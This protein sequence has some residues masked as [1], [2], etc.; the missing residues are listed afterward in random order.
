MYTFY[1][2]FNKKSIEEIGGR[3]I[4]KLKLNDKIN[5]QN[6]KSLT[7]C[8]KLFHFGILLDKTYILPWPQFY[9]WYISWLSGVLTRIKETTYMYLVIV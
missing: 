5:K 4:I 9:A 6:K 7:S 2:C 1:I 3:P 8:L